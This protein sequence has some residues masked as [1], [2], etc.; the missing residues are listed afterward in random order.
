M[1]N[2]TKNE[3]R[4][5]SGRY[6]EAD[7][8]VVGIFLRNIAKKYSNKFIA[9]RALKSMALKYNLHIKTVKACVEG[10]QQACM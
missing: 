7:S 5:L 3:V 4:H 2:L 1:R 10:I 6:R 9:A 8:R